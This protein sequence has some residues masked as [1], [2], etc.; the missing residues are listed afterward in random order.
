[1]L[2]AVRQ[3]IRKHQRSVHPPAHEPEPDKSCGNSS[4]LH[5]VFPVSPRKG[6]SEWIRAGQEFMPP[7]AGLVVNGA[8]DSQALTV[9]QNALS[10]D[11]EVVRT[12]V[13]D[14]LA[15]VGAECADPDNSGLSA[16]KDARSIE[17][18]FTTALS[19]PD[20]AREEAMLKLRSMCRRSDLEPWSGELAR[21][22]EERP[23]EDGLLLVAKS[24]AR[25]AKDA[26]QK[27]ALSP[28]WQED[29]ALLIAQ[30]ALGDTSVIDHFLEELRVAVASA[31]P[32]R[33]SQAID[34]L[35][36]IGEPGTLKA[37]AE[38]LRTPLIRE[39]PRVSAK[40]MRLVVLGGLAY[41]FPDV[42]V[43]YPSNIIEEEDYIA[44]ENFCIQQ[45]GAQYSDARPPFMTHGAYPR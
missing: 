1:M 41:A 45:L 18:L 11:T 12:Q 6:G 31:D 2:T 21:V 30:G 39:V 13:V 22:I 42:L 9:L 19:K 40:S 27:L 35:S 37:V 4:Q 34:A 44:A 24:K 8:P 14:L 17:I 20:Q 43:L 32:E 15:D 16:I 23:T 25:S 33:F 36:K 38:Q 26:V 10:E 3:F 29:R 7:S 5:R 28:E